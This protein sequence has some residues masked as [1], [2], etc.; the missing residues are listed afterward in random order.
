M[1]NVMLIDDHPVVRAGLQ[2]I[3][4]SHPDIHVI[5]TGSNGADAINSDLSDVDVVVMDIQMPGVD[6]IELPAPS[7]PQY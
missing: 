2:T 3:L 6:G 7:I 4:E 5:A 1:I